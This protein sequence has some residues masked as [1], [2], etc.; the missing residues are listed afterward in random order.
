MG[1]YFGQ[2]LSLTVPNGPVRSPNRRTRFV[3]WFSQKHTQKDICHDFSWLHFSKKSKSVIFGQICPPFAQK[4]GKSDFSWKIGLSHFWAFMV[5]PRG[6]GVSLIFQYCYSWKYFKIYDEHKKTQVKTLFRSRDIT[7]QS[8][9]V[10]LVMTSLGAKRHFLVSHYKREKLEL[11]NF[12]TKQDR[13]LKI[14]T[15]LLS[16]PLNTMSVVIVSQNILAGQ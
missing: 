4:T 2:R 10:F 11:Y 16:W 1:E 5:T 8:V 6:G 3:M 9:G 14:C 15:W 7:C 12:P 13:S